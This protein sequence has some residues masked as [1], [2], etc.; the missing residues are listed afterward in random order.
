MKYNNKKVLLQAA[1]YKYYSVATLFWLLQK[2]S[3]TKET[4]DIKPKPEKEKTDFSRIRCPLC[5]WQPNSSSRWWCSDC[6]EPEYFFGGCGTAWNTFTTRGLCP[7]C[8]HQWRW[9]TCLSC[10]GWSLHEDWY[11]KETR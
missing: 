3:L 2:H 6:K 8:N 7:G 10:I 1:L 11:L 5:Q 4:I 9:T